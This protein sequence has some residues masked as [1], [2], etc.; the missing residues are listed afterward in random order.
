MKSRAVFSANTGS[1]DKEEVSGPSRAAPWTAP[2]ALSPCPRP[3]GEE[4]APSSGRVLVGA[5]LAHRGPGRFAPSSACW[6]CCLRGSLRSRRAALPAFTLNF[7]T[8]LFKLT[9]FYQPR[10]LAR[11]RILLLIV[12]LLLFLPSPRCPPPHTT[13][14]SASL[15]SLFPRQGFN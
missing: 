14:V 8:H 10:E 4:G 6:D 11:D 15:G 12:N 2:R 3:R 1:G 9:F 13:P 5:G 7:L